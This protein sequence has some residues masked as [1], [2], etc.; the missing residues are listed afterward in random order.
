MT[1]LSPRATTRALAVV[2]AV[3]TVLTFLPVLGGDFLN[4]DDDRSL[5]GNHGFR[6]VG[7][8]Q[9]RWM[10]TTTLLGHY[11]PLAW[12][13]FGLTYALAGMAP[14]A[15]RAGNLALHALNAV[16]VYHLA[17]HLLAAARPVDAP[18]P[19]LAGAAVA[20]LL[21]AVHPLRAENVGWVS[22]R[23]DLLCGTFYLLAVLA[24]LRAASRPDARGWHLAS[25]AAFA[26][27]LLSKEIAVTLPVSLLLLDAYPL[28]RWGTG[29]RARLA[30]KGGYFAL[31]VAGAALAVLARSQGG[32]WTSYATHGADAR[33]L[34]PAYSLAFYPAKLVWPA[35]LSP[36]YELPAR[37]QPLEWRFLAAAGAVTVIT[38][39]LVWWRRRLPGALVAWLHA[40]V[41]VAPVSG[42][43]HAGSQL[44]A[45]RY[46]YLPGIGFAVVAGG[47]VAWALQARRRGALAAGAVVA[48]GLVTAGTLAL[49]A[50]LS[51]QQS[52][53]WRDS[54][55]LWRA[56]V[57][58]DADC[59]LCRAKLGAALLATGAGR[60]AQPHLR[61]A[62]EL[63]PARA[64]LRIDLGVALA[65]EGREAEAER[66][67]REALRLEPGSVPARANLATLYARQGRDDDAVA[68]LREATAARPDDAR[69]L[70]RLGAAQRARGR[71]PDA[72]AALEQAVTLAPE[73]AEARFWLA[74]AYLD[75]G[76]VQRAAPHLAVLERLD[77]AGAALL[78]G[79]SQ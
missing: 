64:G 68:L 66:E 41:A 72:V 45:D 29:L 75:V 14:W 62:V 42:V 15:Y 6:G 35:D 74:R 11:A 25:L 20:A 8:E 16:L 13:S 24:Y 58:V 56:A 57:A 51:W 48:G 21:F 53:V 78:R 59:L 79:R 55:S 2:V 26:G 12:L 61:R 23:G 70:V 60:E 54:V 30:E 71:H 43:V 19:R 18:G 36:L 50:T 1:S 67:L 31:A 32:T 38:A 22:D 34:L 37:V 77:P 10:F 69:L 3:V 5:V 17:R 49:L 28:R 44:V 40:A 33:L 27:A 52:R 47:G 76:E 9:L 46:S 65:L 7:L 4:W 39:V 73:L 63:A